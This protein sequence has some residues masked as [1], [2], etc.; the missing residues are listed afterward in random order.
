MLSI[1]YSCSSVG[2]YHIHVVFRLKMATVFESAPKKKRPRMGPRYQMEISFPNE[3]LKKTFL[4][5]L[6][7]ARSSLSSSGSRNVDNYRLLSSLLDHFEEEAGLDSIVV[8]STTS[9]AQRKPIL[10][11]SGNGGGYVYAMVYCNVYVTSCMCVYFYACVLCML[12][13]LHF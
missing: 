2:V 5:R 12:V 11:H 6:D 3:D 1:Y 10:K 4:S 13:C 8:P 9:P 7:K